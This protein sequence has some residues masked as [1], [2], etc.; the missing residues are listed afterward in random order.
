M[1]GRAELGKPLVID[2]IMYVE[3]RKARREP[4]AIAK[5]VLERKNNS[6]LTS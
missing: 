5:K 3:G 1:V 4:Q 2:T 6:C